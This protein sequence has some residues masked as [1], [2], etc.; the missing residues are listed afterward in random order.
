MSPKAK[1]DW[2]IVDES[3]EWEPLG[4]GRSR[5][6]KRWRTIGL[7]I[8]ALLGLLGG[9]FLILRHLSEQ[10]TRKL[11]AEIQVT[12]DLEIKALRTGDQ[13]L[14]MSLQDPVKGAWYRAQMQS[15]ERQ[16]STAPQAPVHIAH[17]TLADDIA[18]VHLSWAGSDEP[19]EQVS[20][21]RVLNGRWHHTA[22]DP[23]YWGQRRQTEIAR[24]HFSYYERDEALLEGLAQ[25]IEER[26]RQICA[27]LECPLEASVEIDVSI[28][29][30]TDDWTRE[31][32]LDSRIPLETGSNHSPRL[33][34]MS[35]QTLPHPVEHGLDSAYLTRQ[36]LNYLLAQT[37]VTPGRWRNERAGA[38]LVEAIARWEL[39]RLEPD[40]EPSFV[41]IAEWDAQLLER[42][43]PDD[44]WL[45]IDR[46]WEPAGV[47]SW[48]IVYQTQT[49]I[50]DTVGAV[51]AEP[52]SWCP[53]RQ[54]Q[55]VVSS[56]GPMAETT[57]FVCGSIDNPIYEIL[58]VDSSAMWPG[59]VSAFVDFIVETYGPEVIPDLLSA[60]ARHTEL[61]AVLR[62]ALEV[63]ASA[64]EVAWLDWFAERYGER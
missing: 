35:P 23:S 49:F 61:G 9:A 1:L 13:E 43:F 44:Y 14:F 54:V 10:G 38:D 15:F 56:A 31:R 39:A 28:A 45:R 58:Y 33:Y 5:L 11:K 41:P 32:Y 46:I 48:V 53:D 25:F 16:R 55:V 40:A 22:P 63:E 6:G 18:W 12:I 19:Y 29:R 34:L 20:F 27:D 26:W 60:I 50:T 2:R 52:F 21:Y 24:I 62:E 30:P 57:T 51:E 17:L 7:A 37:V 8:L 4:P 36:L 3:R 47:Q 64:L 59:I 42:A